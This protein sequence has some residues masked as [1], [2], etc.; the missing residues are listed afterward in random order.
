MKTKLRKKSKNNSE[1]DFSKL[2]NKKV[3][4]FIVRTKL[5]YCKVFHRKSNSYR[6]EKNSNTN[7]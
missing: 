5:S 3:K 6:N 2:M 7:I 1:K 4:I